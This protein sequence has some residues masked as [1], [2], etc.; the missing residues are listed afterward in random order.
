[1]GGWAELSW[2]SHGTESRCA[3]A[4]TTLNYLLK[5][6]AQALLALVVVVI[7]NAELRG[8]V[9]G[10]A[11]GYNKGGGRACLHSIWPHYYCPAT[12]A[13]QESGEAGNEGYNDA[14]DKYSGVICN[15][16]PN[17]TARNHHVM[18]LICAGA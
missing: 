14:K 4:Y 5:S 8:G 3:F 1:M 9:N 7:V 18:Q 15:T 11:S 12:T 6:A 17:S 16:T 2:L 13:R 10:G